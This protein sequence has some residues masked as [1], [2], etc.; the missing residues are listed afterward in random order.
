MLAILNLYLSLSFSS[1]IPLSYLFFF[2]LNTCFLFSHFSSSSHGANVL[3]C[4]QQGP[5]F[6]VLVVTRFYYFSP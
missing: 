4:T 3:L 1:N 6:I 5:L 2:F